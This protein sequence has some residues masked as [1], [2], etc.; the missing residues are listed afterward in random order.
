MSKTEKV[1]YF[2]GQ[3][4]EQAHITEPKTMAHFGNTPEIV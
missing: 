4:E 1:G 2:F 3:K